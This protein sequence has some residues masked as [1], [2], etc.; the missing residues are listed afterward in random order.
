MTPFSVE[1]AVT[2]R[3]AVDALVRAAF[4]AARFV[5]VALANDT[6]LA[7]MVF[8]V[9]LSMEAIA[10]LMAAVTVPTSDA[11]L[12][13][14]PVIVELEIVVLERLFTAGE[15]GATLYAA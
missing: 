3:L 8:A 9:R 5:V 13:L 14:P 2:L 12:T 11:L 6:L 4:V 1:V 10:E 7:V 15:I